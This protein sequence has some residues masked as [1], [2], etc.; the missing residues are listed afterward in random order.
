MYYIV[1]SE[2][3]INYIFLSYDYNDRGYLVDFVGF[4]FYWF[5][6]FRRIHSHPSS[7]GCYSIFN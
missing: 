3:L 1:S 2:T 5:P 4:R 7:S 6:C